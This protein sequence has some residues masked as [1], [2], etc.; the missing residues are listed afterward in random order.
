MYRDYPAILALEDGSIFEGNAL[1]AE[2][3]ACGEVVFNTAMTGYQEILTDCSYAG[4]MVTFTYPH[5]GNVGTNSQDEES[6]RIWPRGIIVRSLACFPSNWRSQKTLAEYVLNTDCIIIGDIDTRALTQKL[7]TQGAM[8]ACIMVGDSCDSD[9]AIQMA[10]AFNDL[11]TKDFTEIVSTKNQY[12]WTEGSL[13]NTTVEDKGKQIEEKRDKVK[14]IEKRPHVVVYDFG[15]K[16]NILRC[17]YDLG[18]RV[19]V[20]PSSTPV[21]ELNTLRPDGILLSNGPGDPKLCTQAIQKIKLLLNGDG[22]SPNR[23]THKNHTPMPLPL[24]GICLGHQLLSLAMGGKTVKMKFGHH[25]AN[26]PVQDLKTG[27]VLITSQNH[28]F[29]IDENSLPADIEI[30]HRSLFDNTP[31]GIKHRTKPIWGFQGHPEAS[32][33]PREAKSIFNDFIQAVVDF[34][35]TKQAVRDAVN[36]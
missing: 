4:Q 11:E 8:K 1:Q 29:M 22:Y 36:A 35:K 15:V 34:Q 25:G 10:R 26:H 19:T 24:M 12:T 17:L 13:W 28:N 31:Q 2:G 27:R 23:E 33:G 16:R 9:R 7:R 32:P 5:I 6:D 14:Q 21:A 18:C 20:V 30:T 3:I